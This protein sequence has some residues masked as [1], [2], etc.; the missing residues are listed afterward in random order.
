MRQEFLCAPCWPR[1]LFCLVAWA[2][3]SSPLFSCCMNEEVEPGSGS[4]T[5]EAEAG[6]SL[7]WRP[8][9]STD[10]VPGQPGKLVLKQWKRK[11][12]GEVGGQEKMK[13]AVGGKRD[14]WGRQ[15]DG[16][17]EDAPGP[18]KRGQTVALSLWF[19]PFS[20]SVSWP[21]VLLLLM[22]DV[23][24]FLQ[25]KDQKYIFTSLVSLLLLFF[26][27]F[28]FKRLIY[29]CIWVHTVVVQIVVNVHMVVGNWI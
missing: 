18:R 10:W 24:V 12:N 28:F 5:W 23:L 26:F 8:A 6:R 21:D 3:L 4:H 20:H 1:R 7:S 14:L 17:W 15:G 25:E 13:D 9:W 19:W 29:L 27:F 11:K 2:T 16:V 22:T